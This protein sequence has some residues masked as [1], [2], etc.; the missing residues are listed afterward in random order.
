[1]LLST[2]LIAYALKLSYIQSYASYLET[3]TG[4]EKELILAIIKVESNFN[5]YAIGKTHKERG[6]MQL[7]PTYHKAS[8][9]I[10]DNMDEGVAYL[11]YL[12]KRCTKKY[13]EAWF[14]CYNHGPNKTLDFV[15]DSNYYQKVKAAYNEQKKA[16]ELYRMCKSSST[17]KFCIKAIP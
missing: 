7:R 4:I 1:M 5:Q 9:N 12:K 8:F 2:T 15:K 14:V 16:S 11:M 3:Q 10:K 17:S 6:L 13:G